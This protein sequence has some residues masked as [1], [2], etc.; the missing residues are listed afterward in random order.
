MGQGDPFHEAAFYITRRMRSEW[1]NEETDVLIER[2]KFM[3]KAPRLAL[4][5]GTRRNPRKGLGRKI[6]PPPATALTPKL[7]A[8]WPMLRATSSPSLSANSALTRSLK[9]MSEEFCP[10]WHGEHRRHDPTRQF[11]GA[12]MGATMH[13]AGQKAKLL[14][15][16]TLS[17]QLLL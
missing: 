12:T 6:P 11:L 10:R 13:L 1:V 17:I 16:V 2:L 9:R 14:H 8:R 4:T 5:W 15:Y 3:D 7:F